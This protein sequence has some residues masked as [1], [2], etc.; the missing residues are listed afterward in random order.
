MSELEINV[1]LSRRD[2]R[3][4]VDV[5]VPGHGLTVLLGPSGSGKSTLLRLL[6]GL[7]PLSAGYIRHGA[8]VWLAG[9]K[10]TA[11][12]VQ[13]RRLGFVFQDYALFPHLNVFDNIAYG[14]KAKQR[15]SYSGIVYSWL[16]RLQ[17]E[18][19]SQR[20]PHQ[21]SG[22]QRQRVAL[23][24]ALATAPELLLLDEPFSALDSNLRHDM[25]E[26]LRLLI[27]SV[28]C[29][30]IMVTHDLQDART[31]ADHVGVMVDGRLT[32]FGR[33][34]E[35]FNDPKCRV[36]AE[37][38]GWRNFLSVTALSSF[39]V[40]GAWGRLQLLQDPSPDTDC[41]SI[42]PEHVRFAKGEHDHAIA[43]V[44][45]TI[46]DFGIYREI[47][48]R[49]GDGSPITMHCAWDRPVPIAGTSVQL[50]LPA[51]YVR[52]L[53]NTASRQSARPVAL[54]NTIKEVAQY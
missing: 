43:A 4:A 19:L 49:L 54:V 42:R 36:A 51:Q 30:V 50:C 47:R 21:L 1:E 27:E 23:A 13:K 29:P 8:D 52:L 18:S 10:A 20:F 48:C 17:L 31:L 12:P 3:L 34:T 24:R 39:E 2:F 5:V 38:L 22:G 45:E 15:N 37:L 26:Q 11:L 41:V 7:E 33:A 25:R 9:G 6:A 53:T 40:R 14:V 46:T 16:Q 28:P 35:V 44:I 32:R